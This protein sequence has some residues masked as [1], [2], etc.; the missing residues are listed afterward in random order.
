MPRARATGLTRFLLF[1]LIAAPVIFVG[2]SY[3]RGEDP[4]GQI[5]AWLGNEREAPVTET[6]DCQAL[7]RENAQLRREVARLRGE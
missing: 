3:A 7:Q 5:G 4:F 2:V 1:L 6:L